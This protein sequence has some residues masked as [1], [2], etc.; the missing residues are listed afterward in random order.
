MKLIRKL[1][2]RKEIE[3]PS[4]RGH[5]RNKISETQ[6][7]HGLSETLAELDALPT[8]EREPFED[9]VITFLDSLVSHY[10]LDDGKLV[11]AHAGMKE[12]MQGRASG[13]VRDFALYGET[14]GETDEFGLPVRFDW[15]SAYRGRATVV[16][17]HTPVP[18]PEWLNHT[19]NIDTG[20]VFGGKLTAL[21]YPEKEL[22]FIPA[23]RGYS[24]P[25]RPFLEP[26]QEA[27]Q[28]T[29]QQAH[30]DLLNIADYLQKLMIST[31]L[32][33]N[34]VVREE[35]AAAALE[36]MTPALQLLHS[37]LSIYRLQCHPVQ[38]RVVQTYSNTRRRRFLTS[39][40]KVYRKLSVKKS[41]WVR[42]SLSCYAVMKRLPSN[43]SALLVMSQFNPHLTATNPRRS[44]SLNPISG[45]V[46]HGQDVP[47]LATLK[48][49]ARCSND[50]IPPLM[51]SS[52]GKR[53]KPIGFVLTQN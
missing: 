2:E 23:Q 5:H 20:C 53:T 51:Q 9:K 12:E 11:V 16:Y 46:I 36:V 8:D 10:L 32:M 4:H 13:A 24:E 52:F 6:I 47:S 35:N 29:A 30:D 18:E 43:D 21:R 14:T 7:T 42:V 15:A 19:I 41:T 37:G 17:G 45:S 39:A 34:V 33:G 26:E 50:S 28:L 22:V 44:N 31:R 1:R 3:K 25:V 40:T 48:W 27:P 38:H 49:R